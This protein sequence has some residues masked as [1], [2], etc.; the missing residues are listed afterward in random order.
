M[1]VSVAMFGAIMSLD[2]AADKEPFLPVSGDR[3]LLT[4]HDCLDQPERND[5]EV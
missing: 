1:Y 2:G 5:F 3:Y 4:G